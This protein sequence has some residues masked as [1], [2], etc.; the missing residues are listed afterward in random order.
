MQSWGGMPI[1]AP[2]TPQD[3]WEN[4]WGKIDEMLFVIFQAIHIGGIGWGS[5]FQRLFFTGQIMS[6]TCSEG[7]GVS[8]HWANISKAP[9]QGQLWSDHTNSELSCDSTPH[10][11][12][13]STCQAW[14]TPAPLDFPSLWLKCCSF[15]YTHFLSSLL[16]CLLLT[17]GLTHQ[18]SL[19]YHVPS[20]FP[21]L[22]FLFFTTVIYWFTYCL[23]PPLEGNVHQGGKLSCPPAC[24]WHL[25][26]Q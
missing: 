7:S 4:P 2:S 9:L 3:C 13:D 21:C 24:P 16:Q 26:H 15:W 18:P 25:E 19:T 1:P 14:S 17:D 5:S 23:S 22:N 10:T 12:R 6:L 11:H 8:S 20:P